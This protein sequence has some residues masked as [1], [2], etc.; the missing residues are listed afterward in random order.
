MSQVYVISD[1][2]A[3]QPMTRVQ[4]VN[5]DRELQQLLMRNLDLLP[6]DQM[7]P[8]VPRRWLLIKREMPV[9]DPSTG[10]DRWSIDFL[11]ADQSAIPTFVECKR[12]DDTR[13]RREVVG[14]MLEYAANGHYYWSKEIL[15]SYAETAA[16]NSNETIESALQQLAPDDDLEPDEYFARVQENL[17]EGQLRI[18]FF[19]ERS[20]ME[21]RSV[22]DFLN[23]QME[24]SEVLLVEAQQFSLNGTSVVVPRLF[25]FTEE[26][27]VVKRHV[28][29][30]NAES[31]RK[32]W[33]ERLFFADAESRLLA[34]EVR[35]IRELFDFCKANRFEIGYGNGATFG[36]FQVK[37]P[38]SVNGTMIMVTTDGRLSL[39]FGSLRGSDE[40]ESIRDYLK[41][42]AETRL[43]FAI[44]TDYQDKYPSY[45]M[46][47]W[48]SKVGEIISIL[49]EVKQKLIAF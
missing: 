2:G 44:S 37:H 35:L 1:D 40:A 46:T 20:S 36:S 30:T 43:G 9:P 17:R 6:G 25:G 34:S 28:N 38:P 42:A 41:E 12:Y 31:K 7:N 16:S 8:D 33:D 24:R 15:R 13:A 11:L 5:E 22:V 32:R 48:K 18:V 26:A 4:C 39:Y 47:Q 23:K 27:R 10:G 19:L 21:L 49:R 3:T 29:V 14:Q 45:P